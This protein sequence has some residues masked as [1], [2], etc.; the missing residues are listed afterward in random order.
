MRTLLAALLLGAL[1]SWDQEPAPAAP[2]K[3]FA[4]VFRTGPAWDQEKPPSQQSFFKEH[5]QN[6]AALRKAERIALGGRYAD[7]G[8]IVVRAA[9]VA[10][11]RSLLRDDP[12]LLAGVFQADVHA[13]STIY[14]GCTSAT[15]TPR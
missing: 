13:W 6:L 2:A 8:L 4:V 10:E 1:F 3:L 11:A 12:S 7:V 5:S 14:D 15:P 9:D